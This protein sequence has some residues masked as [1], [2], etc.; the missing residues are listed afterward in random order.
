MRNDLVPLAWARLGTMLRP[1]VERDIY[2]V[3]HAL[4]ITVLHPWLMAWAATA[5]EQHMAPE[6]TG[7]RTFSPSAMSG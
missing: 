7:S 6:P 2:A 3:L 4:Y 5:T 1:R